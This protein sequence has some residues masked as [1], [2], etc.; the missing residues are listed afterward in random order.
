M[1]KGQKYTC[2]YTSGGGVDYSEGQWVIKTL[3]D[4][5]I[6]IEK[7]SEQKVY[8]NYNKGD[9]ISCLVNNPKNA[10]RSWINPLMDWGDGT[11]TIYPRQAGTPYYFEPLI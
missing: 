5:T 2:V 11:F 7:I 4:K 9:R 8:G 6:I 3:T 1:K 10:G